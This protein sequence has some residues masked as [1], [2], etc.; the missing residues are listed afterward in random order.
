MKRARKKRPKG[1]SEEQVQLSDEC[2][3]WKKEKTTL[4][5]WKT[6]SGLSP[7]EQ[8]VCVATPGGEKFSW[9][10][11]CEYKKKRQA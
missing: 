8:W 3:P 9:T 2:G 6:K 11:P 5:I 7:G 10:P 4:G 1:S